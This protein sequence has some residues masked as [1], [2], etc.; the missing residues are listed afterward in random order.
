MVAL[1]IGGLSACD[2]GLSK[3]AV[4]KLQVTPESL[5]FVRPTFGPDDAMT[6]QVENVG[7]GSF[8]LTHVELRDNSGVPELALLDADDL[9]GLNQAPALV[10]PDSPFVMRVAWFPEDSQAG[11]GALDIRTSIGNATVSIV[12]PDGDA[13]M[14]L[15]TDP[16]PDLQTWERT[17]VILDAT[18]PGGVGT[19][20]ARLVSSG[21]ATL[22]IREVC[23][24]DGDGD[25]LAPGSPQEVFGLCD[26][27]WVRDSACERVGPAELRPGATRSFSVVFRP[28]SGTMDTH[29]AR[30]RITTNASAEPLA[31]IHHLEVTATPCR[32]DGPGECDQECFDEDDDGVP[33]DC[34]GAEDNCPDIPNPDQTDTDGDGMGDA[35]DPDYQPTF[36]VSGNLSW[37]SS[38]GDG[39]GS[40]LRGDGD[41]IL[42]ASGSSTRFTVRPAEEW[43]SP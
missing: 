11:R 13:G 30:V 17:E 28:P 39:N 14:D 19:V 18:P 33:T 41:V 32:H 36:T 12:T 35:C 34:D 16:A 3:R 38:D 20:N 2:D 24:V 26:G 43:R 31:P 40:R 10:T 1:A 37:V 6:V 4:P 5:S 29:V 8:E 21:N 22:Q 23:I 15:L 7:G 27:D 42:R 9:A 25:C